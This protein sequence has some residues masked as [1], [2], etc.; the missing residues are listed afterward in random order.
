VRLP[1]AISL[2]G[3]AL[4]LA[5]LVLLVGKVVPLPAPRVAKGLEVSF[6]PPLPAAAP[7]PTLP[8]TQ[9]RPLPPPPVAPAVAAPEVPTLAPE[10]SEVAREPPPPKPEEKPRPPRRRPQLARLPPPRQRPPSSAA[11]MAPVPEPEAP[12]APAASAPISGDYRTALAA[13]FERHKQYPEAARERGEEGRVVL[14]FVVDRSGHVLD[15]EVVRSSG[16]PDL[17]RAVNGMMRGATLPAFPA[18]M[19]QQ[20]VEVSITIRFALAE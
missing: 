5:V 18:S 8:P 7:A 19:P 6:A 3:H 11:P 12:A 10:R 9:S 13:W 1:V 16:H 14:R 2:T 20:R 17:D 4:C 15:H